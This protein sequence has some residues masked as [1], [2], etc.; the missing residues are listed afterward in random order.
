[1]DHTYRTSLLA[2]QQINFV[3]GK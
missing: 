3:F 1:M 2:G